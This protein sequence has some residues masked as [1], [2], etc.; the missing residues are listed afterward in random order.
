[1]STTSVAPQGT[2]PTEALRRA[3]AHARP[4]DVALDPADMGAA[5][6]TRHSFNRSFLRTAARQRWAVDRTDFQLDE[7]GRGRFVYRVTTPSHVFHLVGFS[8]V[9]DESQR[10]DRVV[11]QAWD[12]TAALVEGELDDDLLT[13]LAQEVPRQE[14]GRAPVGTLVWTRANRSARFFDAVA[15][16]LAAGQQPDPAVLGDGAYVLRSTAFY[17]NGKFALTGFDGYPA[18]HPLGL[19]Y[20]AQMLTAW[21][22]R[23]FS[24][25]LVEHCARARNPEAVQLTGAWRRYF[26][27]GNATGL[28]MVPYI[29]NHPTVL[30]AWC[31]LRELPLAHALASPVT[32]DKLD[33]VLEL[34]ARAQRYFARRATLPTAPYPALGTVSDGLGRLR[35]ALAELRDTG[36]LDGAVPTDPWQAARDRA[37]AEGPEV[38]AVLDTVLVEDTADLDDDVESLLHCR[39]EQSWDPATTC[40]QAREQLHHTYAWA[41]RLDLSSPAATDRFWFTSIDNEEPRRGRR[42][43]DA[44]VEVEHPLGVALD[45]TALLADLDRATA[46]E[47]LADFLLTHPTHRGAL[48][49]AL[50]LTE[51]PYSEVR[52]NLL[53]ADFLPLDLQRFQL[54]VYGM[55]NYS[56]QSTDWLRVTLNSGAPR[57]ADIRAGVDDDWLFSPGPTTSTTTPATPATPTTPTTPADA[58]STRST[59]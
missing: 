42:G 48:G 23:E 33:R 52:T 55:D 53:A 36:R 31:A 7:A 1:V 21:L 13:V 14:A 3:Q 30:D 46:D 43:V 19:P 59:R 44:G 56:P 54:A 49:R 40:S 29:V 15:T 34:L 35:D 47:P 22:L 39:E 10:T 16:A 27:L 58:D 41:R 28:G 5:R 12:V 50:S 11:A 8:Q 45:I 20:R 6:A 32:E 17:G 2:R 51:V 24:Y 18:E 26:G 37:A 57:A 38:R 25:D 4:A 9:L